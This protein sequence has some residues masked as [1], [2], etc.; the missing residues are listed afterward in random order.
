MHTISGRG[1]AGGLWRVGADHGDAGQE[2]VLHRHALLDGTRGELCFLHLLLPITA[3]LL[4]LP[5][6]LLR[7][8]IR[9][10]PSFS[11]LTKQIPSTHI[12]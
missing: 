6:N 1:E 12:T 2:E 3:N 7:N 10:M 5:K 11:V 8:Q 9:Q 4:T